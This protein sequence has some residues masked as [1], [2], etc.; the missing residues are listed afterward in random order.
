M[1]MGTGYNKK[2]KISLIALIGL[3]VVIIGAMA[4]VFVSGKMKESNYAEAISSAEKYVLQNRYEDAIVEYK[5]AISVNPKDEEA[6]LGLAELYLSISDVSKAKAILNKG[7]AMTNSSE[8][9]KALLYIENDAGLGNTLTEEKVDLDNIDLAT[10]SEGIKLD[11]AFMQKLVN[12]TF[13]D[14]EDE[15]GRTSSTLK[16]DD[17]FLE[18]VHSKFNGV[19]YYRNTDDNR[20]IVD[21]SKKMPKTSGMPEK[22]TLN[23]L[24]ILFRNFDGVVSLDKLQILLSQRVQPKA[25]DGRTY[26][27]ADL[28]SCI[29][30]IETD[31]AGNI[32]SDT[33]WNE[34]I[35]VNANELIQKAGQMTG[36]VIDAVTGDGV[37]GAS[38]TFVPIGSSGA[39]AVTTSEQQGV[40][41]VELE[42][43]KYKVTVEAEDYITDEFSCEI[44]EGKTYSGVQY[45]LSPKL[46]SGTARIVLEWNSQPHDLDSYL[47]GETDSGYDVN[48]NFTDMMATGGG[49]TLATLDVDDTDGY[50]PETTTI[51]DLNGVYTF[52]VED[53]TNTGTMAQYGATV[54][55]YLPGQSPVTI[56]LDASSGVE[57]VWI[58][59]EID[60]GRLNIINKSGD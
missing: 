32:V 27:E 29:L 37:S 13:A 10:A 24:G 51:L 35:L 56:T 38:L 57:D 42:A 31:T 40:F 2:I 5:K 15:F 36:V 1:K 34:I 44:K 50:G 11:A 18:V 14:F 12:Y 7:F 16:N 46:A 8:I 33:A 53:Y 54:K 22:I 43:G 47:T 41:S 3:L 49:N 6:Y 28:D 55:V 21:D 59:C 48:V 52:S 58:V 39:K 17:G 45:V 4:F 25:K 20:N 60:H 26:I 19:C 30:R 23:S 9:R